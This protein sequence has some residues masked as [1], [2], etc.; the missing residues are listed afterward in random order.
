MADRLR[1]TELDFDT[2]KQN[3]KTFLNQQSQ[4]TD[5]DFEG[6]GLSV[7]LDI[8]AYNTHYQAYYLNMVANEAFMDTALLRDSV[9]SHAKV[10]GYVPYSRKAPVATINFTANTNSNTA[11]TLTIPKGFRFLSNEIDG[12]SYGFV[13]LTETT[14]TKANNNFTFLNLPIYEGQLVTY[15]YNHN[16]ATNPKQIFT[17]PDTSVD[18][19]TISVVVQPSSTNTQVSVYTLAADASNTSMQSEVFYLQENKGQ[20][21]QIYFGGNIIGKKLPDGAVVNITYLVTNGDTANKANNFVA[22]GT[23][24]DSLNNSQSDFVIN[25]VSAAAGG[26]ERESVDE[27]KFSAPLQY[28]TQNR[29]VTTKDYEAYI[30]KNY[31]SISSL[32]VWGGEDEIPPVYGKVFVS[33]KPKDNYYISEA[34][35]QRIIDEIINPKSIISVSTEIRDP[36]Y[37]YI[38]LNNQ[39]R[40]DSKKTTLT[41]TQ[42]STQI[43][44]TIISYKQTFLNKFGAIFAL[45][46]LQDQVDSVDTNSIIGSET[47]L[48]LQKRVTPELGVSSN[49]TINFGVPIKRGTLAD[50]LTTTEFSVFDTTGVSRT[51]IIEEIPQSFTGVSSIE[52]VN[53]GYGYTSTPTVTISGDGTGATAEAIIEG[54][55]I[56]Q[57]HM[58]N[59]GT[60][61]TR[62]TVTISGGGGYSGSATAVIDSKVGTLRVIYYDE[63]ANR[64]IINAHVGEIYYDTG[65][66]QLNDL[67]I[68]SVSASDGLL[69]LTAVSEEGVIESSRNVIITIDD[70]D[71]TSIV[72]TLEKMAT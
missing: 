27:I 69:R 10:L 13:T 49:Y 32:S 8:L 7:L 14:A 50:R 54:G 61:Y 23:L 46:K 15:S 24:T 25:S 59:R 11:S 40:Y 55:R 12:V 22:T 43:R 45:S 5:Y 31:P 20:Q 1:V 66:I 9:V 38:L 56:T 57:I 58:T 72:T 34:E 33:L 2:I 17:L 62:A 4:F 29:L 47:I 44:N 53:A 37:L 67:K 71:A 36:D 64:Q 63:N 42:L 41:E 68:L 39:V 52:I 18:T 16:E 30:K 21:Y 3:L 48:K 51:A 26:A 60:D 35:K 28:T 65:I 70:T 19:T 6:S